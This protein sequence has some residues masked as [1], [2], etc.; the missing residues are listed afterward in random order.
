MLMWHEHEEEGNP[1][2]TVQPPVVS[3]PRSEYVPLPFL[4]TLIPT[5][6]LLEAVEAILATERAAGP[7]R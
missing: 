7:S 4:G 5:C 1:I 6:S 3:D 2:L